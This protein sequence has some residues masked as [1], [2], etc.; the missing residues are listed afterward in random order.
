MEALFRESPSGNPHTL[1]IATYLDTE[2]TIIG[3]LPPVFD[4]SPESWICGRFARVWSQAQ[5]LLP[6]RIFQAESSLDRSI[7]QPECRR[8]FEELRQLFQ[9][10]ELALEEPQSKGIRLWNR[11]ARAT[12]WLYLGSRL[13][14]LVGQMHAAATGVF[15]DANTFD[16][17]FGTGA[18]FHETGAYAQR[19]A[20]VAAL[21]YSRRIAHLDASPTTLGG[22]LGD[23]CYGHVPLHK[24][25]QLIMAADKLGGFSS[26]SSS[27]NMRLWM[28]F[29][30][31][32]HAR[33]PCARDGKL[34]AADVE[35]RTWFQSEF[36]RQA[37]KMNL[38]SWQD[39]EKTLQG[40]L[41]SRWVK[42]PLQDWYSSVLEQSRRASKHPR[43]SVR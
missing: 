5:L 37:H 30:G 35:D 20:V 1:F 8:L 32:Q 10:V 36:G 23:V 41:Y 7:N 2:R 14:F 29:V 26:E 18:L 34:T 6:P 40:F 16:D 28:L 22:P 38:S 33:D 11:R 21:H 9:V 3:M 39:C 17:D 24:M 12:V 19:S 43:V 13:S 4:Y 27:A 42:P 15:S 31:T 25:R